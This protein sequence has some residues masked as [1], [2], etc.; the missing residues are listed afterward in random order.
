MESKTCRNMDKK[1][2]NTGVHF[3]ELILLCIIKFDLFDFRL[4]YLNKRAKISLVINQTI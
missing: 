3:N 1:Q 2:N 4:L